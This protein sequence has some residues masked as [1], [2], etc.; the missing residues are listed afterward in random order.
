V[1]LVLFF[2]Y[3]LC[4]I[5]GMT[6]F[7]GAL[8]TRCVS[9]IEADAFAAHFSSG[10]MDEQALKT[11]DSDPGQLQLEDS[12]SLFWW[13]KETYD[14]GDVVSCPVSIQCPSPKVCQLFRQNPRA[15]YAGFDNVVTAM[16]S[17]IVLTTGDNWQDITY[18]LTDT[19]AVAAPFAY[20]FIG[21]VN[22]ILGMLVVELFTAVICSTFAEVREEGA[23][24]AFVTD[25]AQLPTYHSH[26]SD[27]GSD[28]DDEAMLLGN[29]G[30]EVQHSKGSAWGQPKPAFY[31]VAKLE[32]TV[33]SDGFESLILA[34]IL[35]NS[36]ALAVVHHDMHPTLESILDLSETAFT[37]IFLIEMAMKV[38]ALGFGVYWSSHANKV[39]A[40][41]N[42]LCV[43]ALFPQ[44]EGGEA[45]KT[46]RL[47]RILR[48]FRAVRLVKL[49]IK[50]PSVKQLVDTIFLS[51]EA[52]NNLV[53]FLVY[54]QFVLSLFGMHMMGDEVQFEP[55]GTVKPRAHFSDFLNSFATTLVMTTG[56]RWKVT[57]YSYLDTY[58]IWASVYFVLLWGFCN[59]V[60]LN[61][62]IA[63][64]L[65]NFEYSD[66]EKRAL[67]KQRYVDSRRR[68]A[69]SNWL[70]ECYAKPYP[71][72]DDD[73]EKEQA[74]LRKIISAAT[75]AGSSA[76]DEVIKLAKARLKEVPKLSSK[77]QPQTEE[78]LEYSTPLPKLCLYL[79][80]SW[81]VET[82]TVVMVL[83][84]AVMI[85]YEGPPGGMVDE[86]ELA[87]WF[88]LVDSVLLAGFWVEFVIRATAL[89]FMLS[90]FSYLSHHWYKLDFAV[91]VVC[92]VPLAIPEWQQGASVFRLARLLRP[93]R[94]LKKIRGMDVLMRAIMVSIQSLTGIFVLGFVVHLIFGIVGVTMFAGGWNV[95]SNPNVL[96]RIDCHGTTVDASGNIIV[97][98][99][100]MAPGG[101]FDNIF[102]AMRTLF[103][104]GTLAGWSD[105]MYQGMDMV[106]ADFQPVREAH[107]YAA[108]YFI[109]FVFVSAFFLSNLF[110]GVLITLLGTET[111]HALETSAQAKWVAMRVMVKQVGSIDKEEQPENMPGWRASVH[112]LVHNPKFENIITGTIIG[113]TLIMLMEHWPAD[114][115]LVDFLHVVNMVCLII[116][117]IEAVL[118]IVAVYPRAYIRDNWNRL[119]LFVVTASWV[120]TVLKIDSGVQVA[121][122]IRTVRVLLLLKSAKGLQLLFRTFLMSIPPSINI[123]V[124]MCVDFFI[125]ANVGMYFFGNTQT[126]LYYD[127]RGNFKTFSGSLKLLFQMCTGEDFLYIVHDLGVAPPHCVPAGELD[128]A[129]GLISDYGTCGNRTVAFVFVSL[130]FVVSNY[131][132]LNMI[133]AVIMSN[134]DA[135]LNMD[136]ME[137]SEEDVLGFKRTWDKHV[138]AKGEDKLQVEM[139]TLKAFLEEIG[140]PLGWQRQ[141]ER[142]DVEVPARWLNMVLHE[143]EDMWEVDPK[144]GGLGFDEVLL[145]LSMMYLSTDC[146]TYEEKRSKLERAVTDRSAKIVISSLKTWHRKTCVPTEVQEGGEDAVMSYLDILQACKS[147][148][149]K[150]LCFSYKSNIKHVDLK[151]L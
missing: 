128:A 125:F 102:S 34:F 19:E 142:G 17:M 41:V 47:F 20:I 72:N 26:S 104:V 68:A 77:G 31:Q 11:Y 32:E 146:L 75:R 35:L 38:L 53:F 143:L 7:G 95:C 21:T 1:L 15:G 48:V 116:F 64:V 106:G 52:V 27:E 140:E 58:G 130:F 93:I 115:S 127:E 51:M 149:L 80:R 135:V 81:V 144:H 16:M 3:V 132:L 55:E 101:N 71:R 33:L 57:M 108:V 99:W 63:V 123:I 86:P 42:V 129:T 147:F 133:V 10:L 110:V 96:G 145:T 109:A 70:I 82:I 111:G 4:S 126:G 119:D 44:G 36:V 117:T 22:V 78:D 62:F 23:A 148:R 98:T 94:L 43:A 9:Q 69:H 88:H 54:T 67:Q 87:E 100:D 12:S 5:V 134:F 103:L 137:I 45:A 92:T 118:K 83:V 49:L 56:D 24:S 65:E 39:D 114:P 121:R 150:Y 61:L 46:A 113:N 30:R 141:T 91:L 120:S 59:L 60:I 84:S 112:A 97:A 90:P 2:L 122:C 85:S 76:D 124:L 136:S 50:Y 37:I 73:V 14:I 151:T 79:H 28:E 8:R 131:L 138:V 40:I 66:D 74:T 107:P 89:G 139:D 18:V 25:V 6:L 105:A 13:D 29:A